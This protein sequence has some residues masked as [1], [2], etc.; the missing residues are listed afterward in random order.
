M[1]KNEI[2]AKYNPLICKL[3]YTMYQKVQ[4]SIYD[5]DDC[6]QELRLSLLLYL[7]E[8]YDLGQIVSYIKMTS[9]SCM[10]YM[11]YTINKQKKVSD[12]LKAVSTGSYEEEMLDKV[13]LDKIDFGTEMQKSIAMLRMLG[14]SYIEIAN[15]FGVSVVSI[16]N[17]RD[18]VKKALEELK[19]SECI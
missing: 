2:L 16:Y 12:R 11:V 13:F 7:K 3:A 10:C 9:H 5:Y 4:G 1:T 18:K 19:V 8:S 6:L 17:E 15:M 14:Y